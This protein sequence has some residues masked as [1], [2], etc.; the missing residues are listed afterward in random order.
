M[1]PYNEFAFPIRGSTGEVVQQGMTLRDYFA[2][3]AMQGELAAMS[4][5]NGTQSG[6]A[7]D[8]SDELLT[9]LAQ[10]YYRLADAMLLARDD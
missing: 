9:R 2:A 5:V 7:L 4:N 10:H 1:N 3:I 8:A 6:V